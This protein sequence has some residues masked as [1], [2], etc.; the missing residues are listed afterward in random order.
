MIRARNAVAL[1]VA[2]TGGVALGACQL[3]VGLSGLTV[4]TGTGGMGG[5]T[6][7][8]STTA[9]AT[10]STTA[11]TSASSNASSSSGTGGSAVDAGH[12]AGDAGVDSGSCTGS[13]TCSPACVGNTLYPGGPCNAGA[14]P[15]GQLC[16]TTMDAGLCI[17]PP[18][19]TAMCVSCGTY[20]DMS[21][22]SCTTGDCSGCD[23]DSGVCATP[24]V[25]GVCATGCPDGGTCAGNPVT[26]DASQRAARYECTGPQGCNGVDVV[27]SGP[28]PCTVVC[29]GGCVGLHLTCDA[30]GPCTLA[31][32]DMSCM[33]ATMVC[34]HNSCD[35][36]CTQHGPT[37]QTCGD[38][39]RCTQTGGQCAG[40]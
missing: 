11:S 2:L 10:G 40:P 30:E 26:I 31:C 4:T 27:C 15:A 39:C 29:N 8:A 13:S 21:T 14:C 16:P 12:D 37:T 9:T 6:A 38:A 24:C 32:E 3:V 28:Y 25:S 35:V 17:E 33:G 23:V 20:P 7:S 18:G 36:T 1:A 22:T 19:M 5:G 34:G